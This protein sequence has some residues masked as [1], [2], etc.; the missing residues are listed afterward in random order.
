MVI[1]GS[2]R[3][4]RDGEPISHQVAADELYL[5]RRLAH[6]ACKVM[7]GVK[8]GMGSE[9]AHPFR[10]FHSAVNLGEKIPEKIDPMLIRARFGGTIFPP[11]TIT[12]E[13][14]AESGVWWSEVA[15]QC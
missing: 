8:V 1:Y 15:A 9:L 12:T 10:E 4:T 6:D 14:F 13:P 3:M 11:A 7:E 2:G 5:I